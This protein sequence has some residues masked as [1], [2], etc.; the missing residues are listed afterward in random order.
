MQPELQFHSPGWEHQ[1]IRVQL[2][3]NVFVFIC[4]ATNPDLWEL[5]CS[6]IPLLLTTVSLRYA[7]YFHNADG[8]M[9]RTLFKVF[10]IRFDILV[11]GKVRSRN[12]YLTYILAG[13]GYSYLKTFSRCLLFNAFCL[14]SGW[15]VQHN[16]Y[17]YKYRLGACVN[18]CCKYSNLECVTSCL[19]CFVF[20]FCSL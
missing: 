10:G 8:K 1:C 4:H 18:G 2:Q 20:D 14:F 9:D 7:K 3:V 19:A 16:S 5:S 17:N 13:L 6:Q 12:S 11:H 15:K